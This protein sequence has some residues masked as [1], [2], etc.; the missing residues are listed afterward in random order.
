MRLSDIKI[1]NK[2]LLLVLLFVAGI[3]LIISVNLSFTKED[4][5]RAEKKR[6]QSLVH[7]GANQIRELNALV[8]EGQLSEQQ[9]IVNA[10]NIVHSTA[11]NDDSYFYLI[12]VNGN[13]IAHALSHHLEGRNILHLK[14]TQG[15]NFVQDLLTS[16]VGK[17]EVFVEYVWPKPNETKPSEK[18]GYAERI[19]GTDLIL[20][21]G[22]YLAD[23]SPLFYERIISYLL[24]SG[25]MLLGCVAGA[26]V[27]ARNISQPISQMSETMT[28]LSQG[29]LEAQA[30]DTR[31]QD[32]IGHMANTLRVFRNHLAENRRLQK[33]QEQV[34]FLEDYDP[35][36]RLRNRR[37]FSQAIDQE[38]TRH[39]AQKSELCVLVLKF[40]LIHEI[41]IELG[42]EYRDILV[43]ETAKR[44][45][46][47]LKADDVLA[48]LSE[49]TF[50]ILLPYTNDDDTITAQG[51]QLL[52]ILAEPINVR[53]NSLQVGGRIGVSSFPDDGDSNFQ[54]IG[55]AE[56]A[57]A[58]AKKHEREILFYRELGLNTDSKNIVLWQEM[59]KALELD[60][61]HL[62]F[63]PIFD[64]ERNTPEVAEVLL[65][66]NHPEQGFI[67]PAHFIPVAEQSGLISRLDAWVLEA[68]ARQCRRWLDRKMV[69]P[70]IAVNLSGI[71]FMRPDFEQSLKDI[72]AKYQVPLSML[73]LELT[74]GMLIDDLE[75]ITRQLTSIRKT[76][77]SISIDDFGTGYSSLSR[78]KSLDIDNVKID[79]S[80]IEEVDLSRQHRK[81]V[82]AIILMTHGLNLKV[83]AEGVETQAQLDELR[84]MGC[85][86]VQGFF[87]S[88][89][90]DVESFEQLLEQDLVIEVD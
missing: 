43:S 44:I 50:G 21:S 6:L 80:F 83:V 31:R 49:D 64:L 69:V 33:V 45:L 7:N 27:I 61:F 3:S 5:L 72:F 41:T 82:E 10:T 34:A 59:Q 17:N 63:Q 40:D 87:L 66:W 32:E 53:D 60:Q 9:F 74:E 15:R 30:Q 52:Q 19:L 4:V 70:R 57:V 26:M 37:S 77:V 71:S 79:R 89:P 51:Q 73:E 1:H 68:V 13:M 20:G 2:L 14:D 11:T 78:I 38:I 29:D 62:V 55:R 90:L 22:L 28:R 47:L 23:V 84:L 75:Q 24:L 67:S 88:R 65:R 39:T 86:T 35:V 58:A 42:S 36:T 81:I 18:L 76:G 46:N 25:I 48:R 8:A 12:D 85:D 54:L 56:T 16:A